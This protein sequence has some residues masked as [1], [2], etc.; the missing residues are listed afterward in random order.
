[1]RLAAALL[2]AVIAVWG[3]LAL[4]AEARTPRIGVLFVGRTGPPRSHKLVEA[5]RRLG[6]VEGQN[7]VYELRA[8][9]SAGL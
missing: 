4:G 6:Y 1:M 7:V 5:L 2:A 9:A 8:A 3:S